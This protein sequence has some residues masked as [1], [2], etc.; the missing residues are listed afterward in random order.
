MRPPPD[1]HDIVRTSLIL[2]VDVIAM[3]YVTV[4]VV[5]SYNDAGETPWEDPAH[6]A[7]RI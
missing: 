1:I 2:E 6:N 5:L 4:A 7:D 3:H